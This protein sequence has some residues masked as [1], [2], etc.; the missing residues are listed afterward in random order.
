MSAFASAHRPLLVDKHEA[1]EHSITQK[2]KPKDMVVIVESK[3]ETDME[4]R[5]VG[6]DE[7][8][9]K[10]NNMANR[11]VE[12]DRSMVNIDGNGKIKPDAIKPNN[13]AI[14]LITIPGIPLP[15]VD[16][17]FHFQL[18]PIGFGIEMGGGPQLG[19]SY[20]S[21]GSYPGQPIPYSQPY[22]VVSPYSLR[23]GWPTQYPYMTPNQMPEPRFD[24]RHPRSY[25][26]TP[27]EGGNAQ[28]LFHKGSLSSPGT[29]N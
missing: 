6:T 3:K 21:Q 2:M 27:S 4:N 9:E 10:F 20:P 15:G 28:G 25:V 1:F 29:N 5:M 26:P 18:G 7:G 22:V 19:G 11:M 23:Y 13:L 8:E 16:G 14:G 12:A 24:P 17:G